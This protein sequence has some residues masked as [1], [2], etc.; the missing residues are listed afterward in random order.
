M[1]DVVTS[2]R[3]GLLYQDGT[4][5]NYTF[6]GVADSVLPDVVTK[7]K[8]INAA[9]SSPFHQTFVSNSGSPVLRIGS[10]QITSAEEIVIY[11]G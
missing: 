8:A 7:I 4:T 6:E 10:G 9:P 2:V 11:E 3:V 5:R 1:A